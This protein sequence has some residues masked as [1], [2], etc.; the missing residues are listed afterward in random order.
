MPSETTD[1]AAWLRAQPSLSGNAPAWDIGD[2]P[3]APED[4]FVA[5]L[6][7]A[8]DD[9]VAEP[10]AATLATVGSDGVPDARTLILKDVDARGWAF[11]GPRASRKAAQLA[12]HPAGALNFWWQPLVRAVRVRG[13]VEEASPDESAADL[14][15]RP[16]PARAGLGP[17]RWVL[18]RLIP[19]RVEFWQGAPDRR[20]TR[21]V[22]ER[23][24]GEWTRAAIAGVPVIEEEQPRND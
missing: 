8:I 19:E 1:V 9:G 15:S 24:D 16:A 10:L 14:A 17:D 4:L 21:I 22:Y 20:H 18:W 7:Q 2:L 6:T 13:H 11:A 12:A 5:W 3:A 23:R